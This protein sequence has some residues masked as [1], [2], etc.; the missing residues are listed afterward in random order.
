MDEDFEALETAIR[1]GAQSRGVPIMTA[2]LHQDPVAAF[3]HGEV[4]V[5]DVLD[6]VQRRSVPFLVLNV[7]RS[8]TADLISTWEGEN[9]TPPPTELLSAW[10]ARQG[11]IEHISLQWLD[12]AVPY[13]Y[14]AI[15]SWKQDLLD[16]QETWG[17][18]QEEDRQQMVAALRQRVHDLATRLEQDPAYRAGNNQTRRAI[19]TAFLQPL[20]QDK[21]GTATIRFTLDEAGMRVRTNA[22]KAASEL[23]DN[24]R[25][26]EKELA[27]TPEWKAA[28]GRPEQTT[29]A[30]DF[31][32]KK[33]GGYAPPKQLVTDLCTNINRKSR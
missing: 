1:A 4:D 11:Q 9:D 18:E 31:L 20:L 13:L 5:D 10:E 29:V 33:T 23:I 7:S 28:T 12:G 26:L 32:L 21:E 17:E 8:D 30:R 6:L 2:R 14:L 15:P 3:V 24:F 27:E 22:A 16:R 25:Q 19:G